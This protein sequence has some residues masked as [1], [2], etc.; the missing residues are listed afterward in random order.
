M[1]WFFFT[2]FYIKTSCLDNNPS[3]I[4]KESMCSC[5]KFQF[6]QIIILC[7]KDCSSAKKLLQAS[8]EKSLDNY[9]V[10][11]LS[12]SLS[13]AIL[14]SF[15]ESLCLPWFLQFILLLLQC[16][17]SIEELFSL[18]TREYS[19]KRNLWVSVSIVHEVSLG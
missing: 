7:W 6:Y 18:N 11:Q 19:K 10:Q 9:A 4:Q 15:D 8:V 3:K 14:Y 5:E 17:W 1:K 2:S 12:K 13:P 16:I